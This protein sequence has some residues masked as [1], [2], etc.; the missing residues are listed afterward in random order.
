MRRPNARPMADR[1]AQNGTSGALEPAVGATSPARLA[2]RF[3]DAVQARRRR[4]DADFVRCRGGARRVRRL[5][6]KWLYGDASLAA[7]SVDTTDA[8]GRA[9]ASG[10]VVRLRTARTPAAAEAATIGA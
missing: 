3:W 7:S 1:G 10:L 5:R 6:P 8:R 2:A 9:H 4:A